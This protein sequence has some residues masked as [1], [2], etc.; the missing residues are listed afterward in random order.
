[1][2]Y[3]CGKAT[4]KRNVFLYLYNN[5]I[6]IRFPMAVSCSAATRA[7]WYYNIIQTILSNIRL[8][9]PPFFHS[10]FSPFYTSYRLG[11]HL[12][13]CIGLVNIK[14]KQRS[15]LWLFIKKKKKIGKKELPS[16]SCLP[17]SL[18]RLC[19]PYR[20][21]DYPNTFMFEFRIILVLTS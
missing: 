18:F 13:S 16:L 11:V 15:Y 12:Y 3:I 20:F 7:L 17:N 2:L 10:D 6:C 19:A 9:C 5:I 1:M 8:W 4:W 14:T 21:Y